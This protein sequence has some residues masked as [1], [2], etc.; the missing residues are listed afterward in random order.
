MPDLGPD[1]L[2]DAGHEGDIGEQSPLQRKEPKVNGEHILT[3]AVELV[4]ET[5]RGA[6]DGLTNAAVQSQTGLYLEVPNQKG[7]ISWTIL[8]HL[9]LTGQVVKRGKYYRTRTKD[10]R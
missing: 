9:V 7:Y 6:P 5:L 2:N 3:A 1:L 8:N 10:S 4:L